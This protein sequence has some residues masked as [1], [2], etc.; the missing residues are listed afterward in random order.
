MP[1]SISFLRAFLAAVKD[2]M[3]AT[4]SGNKFSVHSGYLETT[5]Q[6][7]REDAR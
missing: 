5:L 6:G 1:Y 3:I 2:A 4:I 7:S